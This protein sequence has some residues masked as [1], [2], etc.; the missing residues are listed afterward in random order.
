MQKI[1]RGSLYLASLFMALAILLNVNAC[2]PPVSDDRDADLV[3]DRS[4]IFPDDACEAFDAD[5]DGLGDNAD[6]DD[7]NDAVSD[8]VEKLNH[9]DPQNSA[10]YPQ[11]MDSDGDGLADHD[12]ADDD[13]DLVPDD[14]EIAQ[15]SDPKDPGSIPGYVPIP[16]NR[17]VLK[18]QPAWYI[19]DFHIH[20]YPY[21]T[22]VDVGPIKSVK[23][24]IENSEQA[25]LDFLAITDHRTIDQH[26]DENYHSQKLIL[27][28]AMEAGGPS[29]ANPF[30]IRTLVDTQLLSSGNAE[31]QQAVDRVHAQGGIF[32]IN[33]P[34]SDP[35]WKFD[36][37]GIDAIEVWNALWGFWMAV[38]PAEYPGDQPGNPDVIE[39]LASDKKLANEEA[40]IFYELQLMKGF[41]LALRS[42][43]DNHICANAVCGAQSMPVTAVYAANLSEDAILDGIRQAR[44]YITDTPHSHRINFTA[45]SEAMPSSLA[46]IGDTLPLGAK[47]HFRIEVDGN[48]GETIELIKNRKIV[49]QFRLE[50]RHSELFF[51]DTPDVRSWYRLNIR[52][53]TNQLMAATTSAIYIE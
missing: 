40:L 14:S 24:T 11:V 4:D 45:T 6:P 41:H 39:A 36:V 46:M 53:T 31:V 32:S 19:G 21:S 9:T 47:I 42:G 30:G 10:S 18:N 3:P 52:E 5:G 43:S 27:I 50:G 23:N 1:I 38:D 12:D 25:G 51:D 34:L 33:H 35:T 22:D 37:K 17:C 48:P 15:G 8:F 7:D 2:E 28:S 20:T 13:N 44:T 26:F 49:A 16:K 29:H